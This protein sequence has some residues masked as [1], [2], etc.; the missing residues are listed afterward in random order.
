MPKVILYLLKGVYTHLSH[1]QSCCESDVALGH[2]CQV[3][4]RFLAVS[5]KLRVPDLGCGASIPDKPVRACSG[6]WRSAPPS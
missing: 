6:C 4:I 5:M 1:K 2:S 3:L